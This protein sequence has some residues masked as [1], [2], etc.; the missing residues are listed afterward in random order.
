VGGQQLWQSGSGG[1]LAINGAVTCSAGATVDFSTS[2]VT[3]TSLTNVNGI[4]GGWATMG[5]ASGA[6][7]GDW[8]ANDGSGN[9]IPYTGYTSV[10][11]TVGSGG[12]STLNYNN[13]AGT[14][15]LS[16]DT[17]INSLV[18]SN[19]VTVNSGATLTLNSGGLMMKGISRWMLA[20]GSTTSFLT[21]GSSN[22]F[23]HTPNAAA[24]DYRIWPLIKDNGTA[25]VRLVKDGAGFL[26]LANNYN[27]YSGGTVVNA[28]ILAYSTVIAAPAT[29]SP[30][31]TGSL[32]IN[33][34]E[35]RLGTSVTT[36]GGE[37][38]YTN[39]VS[40]NG[41][42]INEQDG[43]HHLQG[44]L[45]V[46][47][48]GGILG[49]TYNGSSDGLVNGFSKGLFFDGSV[50]GTGNLTLQQS[51]IATGNAWNTS[52]IYF[53]GSSNSYSGT[54][55]VTPYRPARG[56]AATSSWWEP[57]PWPMRRSIWRGITMPAM[58]A[59]ARRR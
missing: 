44:T 57:M 20:G 14:L 2:G 4:L 38:D 3:S 39:D 48:R 53:T 29:I 22:L 46:G 13:T 50:T 37:Y 42:I 5:A 10:S 52:V 54:I 15:T 27:T 49:A 51:G 16:V 1:T 36:A 32:T 24:T 21:S 33:G 25:T 59:S 26:A 58:A 43:F 47:S 23:V 6:L 34:G 55:T 31:G 9:I 17:V 45:A 19:D 41:G 11:G 8:A 35:V 7:S 18:Q 56:G 40:L 28:G 12:G 30:F